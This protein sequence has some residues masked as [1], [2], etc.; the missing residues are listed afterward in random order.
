[1]RQKIDFKTTKPALGGLLRGIYRLLETAINKGLVGA[2]GFEPAA[3]S[4]RTRRATKLRY[5]PMAH[6]F[7]EKKRLNKPSNFT[8]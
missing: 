1:M 4:S 3:F 7:T 6:N 2:T 5:A 8:G